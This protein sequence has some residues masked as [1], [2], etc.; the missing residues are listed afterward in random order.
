MDDESADNSINDETINY[1][2]KFIFQSLLFCLIYLV[3]N[4]V[5]TFLPGVVPKQINDRSLILKWKRNLLF[6]SH[7]LVNGFMA[8]Y[9]LANYRQLILDPLHYFD[10]RFQVLLEMNLG[11]F[12]YDTIVNINSCFEYCPNMNWVRECL[13]TEEFYF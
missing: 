6:C 12:L 3:F 13:V 7:S 10:E 4:I 9:F 5:I 11:Y 1:E 8:F 2:I